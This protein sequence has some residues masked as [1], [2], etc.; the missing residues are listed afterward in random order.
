MNDTFFLDTDTGSVECQVITSFYS[1][2]TKKYYLV[3]EYVNDESDEMYVSAYDPEDESNTLNDV[4]SEELEEVANLL[5][6]EM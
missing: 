1:E 4:S 3:Y 2:K 6:E 5:N